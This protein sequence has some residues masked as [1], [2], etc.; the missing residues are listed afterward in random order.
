MTPSEFYDVY[1][2]AYL[3]YQEIPTKEEFVKEVK[4]EVPEIS[5]EKLTKDFCIWDDGIEYMYISYALSKKFPDVCIDYID[6]YNIT[7][8]G[9]NNYNANEVNSY[10][11]SLG[12][13]IDNYSEFVKDSTIDNIT[14]QLNELTAENVQEIYKYITE[15]YGSDTISSD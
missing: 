2:K 8:S 10:V 9:I 15:K 12:Y 13:S 6:G 5:E 11:N 4:G 7:I 1:I 14:Y 3:E